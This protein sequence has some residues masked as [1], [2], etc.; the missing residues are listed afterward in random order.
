M[1]ALLSFGVL[2]AFLQVGPMRFREHASSMALWASV[3]FAVH[4]LCV[5]P[6]H[7]ASQTSLLLATALA[8]AAAGSFLRWL[9]RGHGFH[10]V[11]AAF[12]VVLAGMAKEPGNSRL[13]AGDRI[14][15]LHVFE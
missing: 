11:L 13:C 15:L 14:Q 8:M 2:R 4:P 12:L 5:E 9:R 7:Y 10:V 6:V 3:L 1:V